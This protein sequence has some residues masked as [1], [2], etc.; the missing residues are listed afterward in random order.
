MGND[1]GI[2][3]SSVAKTR[4]RDEC[5][6]GTAEQQNQSGRFLA[7]WKEIAEKSD[8]GQMAPRRHRFGVVPVIFRNVE[9]KWL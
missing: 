1:L 7:I 2:T 4:G 5:H 3:P 9:V 6:G 8:S